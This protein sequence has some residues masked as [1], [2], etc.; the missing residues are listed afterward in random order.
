[1]HA[2]MSSA[3]TLFAKQAALARARLILEAAILGRWPSPIHD[4]HT[5]DKNS[6]QIKSHSS[7]RLTRSQPNLYIDQSES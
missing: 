7:L 5:R 1:M 2:S 3:G 4:K 6:A